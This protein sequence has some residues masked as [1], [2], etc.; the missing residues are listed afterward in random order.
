M[1]HAGRSFI[2]VAV[3]GTLPWISWRGAWA[4]VFALLLATEVCIT[5]ARQRAG[6]GGA[7]C[8]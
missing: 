2:Y 5:I 1:L 6:R 8:L 7:H 4:A 3:Y